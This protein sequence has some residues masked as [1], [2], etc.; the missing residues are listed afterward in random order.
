[1]LQGP[2]VRHLQFF[3]IL[4]AACV[5]AACAGRPG[6]ETLRPVPGATGGKAVTVYVATTRAR[7]AEDSAV[8]TKDRSRS[9]NFQRYVISVPP[10]HE[11]GKLELPT[12]SPG[13]PA[14]AFVVRDSSPLELGELKAAIGGRGNPS[15]EVGVFVHGYN[16]S[17]PEAVFRMAQIA[18]DLRFEGR[19]ILFSWPSFAQ[20]PAYVADRESANY[21]R[22][23]LERLLDDVARTPGVSKVHLAAHSMGNWLAAETFRQARLRASSPFVA[24]LHEMVLMSPDV[25]VDV[26]RTQLDAIGKLR[27]PITLLVSADDTALKVSERLAGDVSRVG[28]L[29]ISDERLKEFDRVHKVRVIDLSKV[30]SPDSLNHSKFL[31]VLPRLHEGSLSGRNA[32]V[33]AQIQKGGLY[34]FDAARG[35]LELPGRLSDRIR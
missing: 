13:D 31:K 19:L 21:S 30:D 6:P 5:L 23:Y 33:G 28:N 27:L 7:S 15:G 20:V 10:G 3:P 14:S 2:G 32:P 24:K 1:M 8:F 25:D 35:V 4:L 11:A 17:Y 12:A 16:T 29:E 9:L 26:F 34:V 18:T 22:D